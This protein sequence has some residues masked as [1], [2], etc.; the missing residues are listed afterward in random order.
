[1]LVKG[2]D[3][4]VENRCL[5]FDR[6]SQIMQF[7]VLGSQVVLIARNQPDL[8][9]GNKCNSSITIP[10][11]FEQPLGVV[12]RLLDGRGQHGVDRGRHGTL[13]RAL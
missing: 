13:D 1:M 4:P 5:R 3:F 8:A 12:K 11:D 10:L 9:F 7:R 2:R 6:G